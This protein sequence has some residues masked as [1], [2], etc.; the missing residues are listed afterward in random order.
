MS[1]SCIRSSGVETTTILSV[2]ENP[3]LESLTGLNIIAVPNG[4]RYVST[5]TLYVQPQRS[6][7]WEAEIKTLT[8][9]CP[10]TFQLR[11]TPGVLA[12]GSPIMYTKVSPITLYYQIKT[13]DDQNKLLNVQV[14]S[15]MF[16]QVE[17]AFQFVPGTTTNTSTNGDRSF[18]VQ[19]SDPYTCTSN[20]LAPVPNVLYTEPEFTTDQYVYQ[21]SQVYDMSTTPPV[22][23]SSSMTAWNGMVTPSLTVSVPSTPEEYIETVRATDPTRP[24]LP[25]RPTSWNLFQILK[26]TQPNLDAVHVVL[27]GLVMTP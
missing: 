26:D 18:F 2:Y 7:A 12:N 9:V 27:R 21:T 16:T 4:Q 20:A 13:F 15:A 1:S 8:N 25:L 19:L 14:Y 23:L 11:T 17:V 24:W 22:P 3:L 6:P 5:I 10:S